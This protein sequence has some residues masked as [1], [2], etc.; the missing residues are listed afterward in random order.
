MPAL[1]PYLSATSAGAPF[2]GLP[3]GERAEPA[4]ATGRM[5]L[6]FDWAGTLA[7]DQELTWRLTD[8]VIRGAGYPSVPF[9]IYRREFRLPAAGFYATYCPGAS[10][11]RIEAAFAEACRR[12]YPGAVALHAGV[13]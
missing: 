8:Q 10:W 2:P 9:E 7:D 12:D 11:E 1:A 13:R 4:L 5:N 3:H 6:V